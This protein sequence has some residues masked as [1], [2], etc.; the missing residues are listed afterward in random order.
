[1]LKQ[2][3]GFFTMVIGT[4]FGVSDNLILPLV[5]IAIGAVLMFSGKDG[6]E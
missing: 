1:M 4:G 2:A 3:I 6:N 5:L